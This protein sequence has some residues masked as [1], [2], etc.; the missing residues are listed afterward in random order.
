MDGLQETSSSLQDSTTPGPVSDTDYKALFTEH[1][2]SIAPIVRCTVQDLK[3]K[4]ANLLWI[5]EMDIDAQ[6]PLH[7]YGVDSLIAVENRK[8]LA[9]EVRTDLS[10]F[11]LMRNRSIA[12]LAALIAEKS[13]YLEDATSG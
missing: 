3:R 2:D 12:E 10:I 5:P 9:T 7:T 4:L 6:R 1:K 13:M 8:W 11:Q